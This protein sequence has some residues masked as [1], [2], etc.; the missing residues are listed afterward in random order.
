[1]NSLR[2]ARTKAPSVGLF[3]LLGQGNLG[4][5]ASL[6]AVLAFLRARHPDAVVDFLCSGP[7][8]ITARYGLPA[9]R[10][11]WYSPEHQQS[12]GRMTLVRKAG[13]MAAGLVIDAFRIAAW[14]RRHDVVI[15]P[16]MG[17]LEATVPLRPWQT[18]Y[19]LFLLS[20]SGRMFDTKVAL[21]S[22]GANVIR[23]R[24]TRG[25]VTAAGRMASYRSFRDTF[26]RD[27]MRRMGVDTSGDAVYPDLVFSLPTPHDVPVTVGSVGVGVMDYSGGNDDRR[28]AAEIRNRYIETM[29]LFVLWLVDNGRT[30]RLLTGDVH[31]ERIV[32]EILAGVRASRPDVAPLRLTAEPVRSLTDLMRQMASVD[33]VVGTRYHNVICA[34]K[35]SKPT[36]S[37]GYAKKFEALMTE[38]GMG[39]FC[40]PAASLDLDRLIGQFTEAEKRASELRAAMDER[41]MIN[42]QLLERQ[43][44]LLS[45]KLFP[46]AQSGAEPASPA[47]SPP[48]R[49]R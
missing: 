4:N 38:T 24:L 11:R 44:A 32:Q 26:S 34:L 33:T 37:I 6:E 1:V 30:V 12:S 29:K 40:Q 22:V 39:E 9:A 19:S 43:F 25:L 48:V 47:S 49:A 27:A 7:E 8:Q 17:V 3:G 14:V 36:V 28:R 10:I 20:V 31:D 41:N 46:S 2:R 21:I 18:P 23:Q 5:D 45:G 42:A 15:V 35:L 16:G 13:G